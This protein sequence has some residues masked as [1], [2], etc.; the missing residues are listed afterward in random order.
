MA[1]APAKLKFYTD[2]HIPKAVTTQ[3]RQ[4]GVDIVRCED[5]GL[6]DADD[7]THLTFA[8]LEGRV[9]ITRD[10]DFTRLHTSY[11]VEG[12]FHSG[13]MFCSADIQGDSA[14]GRIV[15]EVLMYHELIEGGAGTVVDDIFNRVLFVS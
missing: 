13:I 4:R 6:G 2:K 10:A 8:T 12:K 15:K 14:V 5:V 11:Q 7:V 3:L 1:E 9:V